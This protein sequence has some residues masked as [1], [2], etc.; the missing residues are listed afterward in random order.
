MRLQQTATQVYYREQSDVRSAF[1]QWHEKDI[2]HAC[3]GADGVQRSGFGV[4]GQQLVEEIARAAVLLG[5]ARGAASAA[6]CSLSAARS[7]MRIRKIA[8]T[9]ETSSSTHRSTRW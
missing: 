4:L 5:R 9:A 3:V 7:R 8:I 2:V 1:G 6:A